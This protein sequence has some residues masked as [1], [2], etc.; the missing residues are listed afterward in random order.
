MENEEK[1]SRTYQEVKWFFIII[2]IIC[3]IC[4]TLDIIKNI[5]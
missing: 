1:G 4:I 2:T 3:A 5:K